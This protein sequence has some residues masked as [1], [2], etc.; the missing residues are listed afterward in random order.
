MRKMTAKEVLGIT[1]KELALEKTLDRITVSEIAHESGYSTATF[2]RHFKDKYDLADWIYSND[3]AEIF[4]T[5]LIKEKSWSK[6]LTVVTD[7]YVNNKEYL[8]NFVRGVDGDS[9]FVVSMF[10]TNYS[11]FLKAFE[12]LS[13]V[14]E[15]D[16]ETEIIIR[17]YSYGCISLTYEWLLGSDSLDIVGLSKVFDNMLP[18]QLRRFLS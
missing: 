5:Y 14:D 7:Y 13:G 2:Y 4:S 12:T 3:L 6:V 18:E 15:F 10:K 17:F 11:L 16:N 9:P 8:S 1:L